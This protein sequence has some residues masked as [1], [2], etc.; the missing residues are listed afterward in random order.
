IHLRGGIVM[1][2][3][4]QKIAFGHAGQRF[5]L[6]S[7]GDG[8]CAQI[9]ALLISVGT[10]IL[11]TRSASEVDLG[12]DIAGQILEQRK[13][14]LVAGAVV[15]AFSLSPGLPKIPFLVIGGIFFAIGWTL[16]KQPTR[17]E[18]EQAEAA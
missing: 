16:K 13:A 7:V 8:L 6:L 14:P 17:A 15:M 3:V 9:P 10:G 11:V 5:S 12:N 2:V 4:Q 1:G 18:R